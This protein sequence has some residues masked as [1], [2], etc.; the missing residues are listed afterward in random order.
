MVGNTAA[1]TST[2]Q[3]RSWDAEEG[4]GVI[5]SPETPGGCWL[6]FSAWLTEKDREPPPG[7]PVEFVYEA[8]RQDGY[9][10]RALQAWPLGAEPARHDASSEPSSAYTS[11]GWFTITGPD[12]EQITKPL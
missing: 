2:G 11:F 3:I 12:G 1:M 9:D 7:T 4:W 5:D 6:H 10:F 8:G